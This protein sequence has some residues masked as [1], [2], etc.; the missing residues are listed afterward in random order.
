MNEFQR[1]FLVQ[2]RADF[3]VLELLRSQPN[4]PDCH[5]LHYLQMATE[6]LGKAHAWKN[7]PRT[8][9]HRAFVAF[10]RS[11]TTNRNAQRQLGFGN[12]NENWEHLI[13]KSVPLA[14]RIEDLAPALALDAPN[15]EYPWPRQEPHTAPAE[16]TFDIWQELKETAA[17]RKFLNVLRH[18]FAV[19]EA[20]L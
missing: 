15:A 16:Y 17:G 10:L 12:R 1:L 14:E 4:L 8:N 5:V 19:A 2:A 11:L 3:A 7:G 20:F 9:T 18:L 13:R 6:L